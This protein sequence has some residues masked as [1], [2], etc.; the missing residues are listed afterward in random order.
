M[1]LLRNVEGESSTRICTNCPGY[2]GGSFSP[3]DGETLSK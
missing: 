1:G 3:V 2:M